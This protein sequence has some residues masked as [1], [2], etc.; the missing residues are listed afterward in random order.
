MVLAI[1]VPALATIEDLAPP[2]WGDANPIA[3]AVWQL[4]EDVDYSWPDGGPYPNPPDGVTPSCLQGT[5]VGSHFGTFGDKNSFTWNDGILTTDSGGLCAVVGVPEG[6]GNAITCQV[7]IRFAGGFDIEDLVEPAI[8]IWRCVRDAP[9]EDGGCTPQESYLGEAWSDPCDLGGGYYTVTATFSGGDYPEDT[10]YIGAAFGGSFGMQGII[11]DAVIHD[12]EDPPVG[13]GRSP[14]NPSAVVNPISIDANDMTIYE[15]PVVLPL[16]DAGNFTVGLGIQPETGATITVMIDPNSGPGGGNADFTL[17][18]SNSG[19]GPG[20]DPCD[21]RVYLTFTHTEATDANS[22]ELLI[23]SCGDDWN[24]ATRTSCWNCPQV[25]RFVATHDEI[26]EEPFLEELHTILVQSFYPPHPTD[27]NY[28]NEKDLEVTVMD[29]DQANILF[30]ITPVEKNN[31]K[32]PI[33][34]PVQIWEQ[35]RLNF[36]PQWRRIDVKLQVEPAN[37]KNPGSPGWVRILVTNDDLF[38]GNPPIMDPPLL[39]ES[40]VEPNAI[41]FT[42]DGSAVPGVIGVVKQWDVSYPIKIWGNEDDKLQAGEAE[43]EGGQNYGANIIFT[44]DEKGSSD[45]RYGKMV[46]V[47]DDYGY[48]VEPTEWEWEGNRNLVD[49]TIDIEIEDNECGAFGILPMDI[50]NPYYVTDPN[51]KSY[52]EDCQVDIYDLIEVARQWF[53][54]SNPLDPACESYI[55]VYGFEVGEE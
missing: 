36:Y 16:D 19:P 34:G 41:V 54:C 13:P 9:P 3:T 55:G 14:C 47:L 39:P 42:S 4:D 6:Q 40:A 10:I 49:R 18:G 27:A 22:Y 45:G 50:S 29:N 8:Q 48:P 51:Y 12:G 23:T 11:V 44:L 30:T 53:D 1:A 52:D 33:T 28:A 21:N 35:R 17:L 7:T 5:D 25:V 20:D 43:G 37:D 38:S 32:D 46:V 15:P 31:P 26:A 24:P 2:P